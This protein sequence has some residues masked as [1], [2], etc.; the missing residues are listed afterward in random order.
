MQTKQLFAVTTSL[1]VLQCPHA[2]HPQQLLRLRWGRL[3]W[4]AMLVLLMVAI[5]AESNAAEFPGNPKTATT[6]ARKN[7]IVLLADDLGW[8][9]VGFHGG[10]ASTPNLDQLAKEGVELNRF[11][12]YPACSPARAAMLTGRFPHRFGITGPT[13]PRDEGLPVSEKMLPAVFQSAGYQ[14]SLIGK[15]HLGHAQGDAA[16]PSNRGF[17]SF[18][19]FMGASVDYFE[20]TSRSRLDWQRDGKAIKEEGYSTDL[21]TDEAIRQIENRDTSKPFCIVLSFNAPHTPLQAPKELIAKYANL[22]GRTGTYAAMIESMDIGIG[23]ILKSIDDQKLSDETIVV[24]A[25]DNGAPRVGV[26]APFR[27]QKRQVYEGGIHVPCI[28]RSPG[29]LKAGTKSNQLAKIDD[30]FPTLADATGV[31]LNSV[32]KPLDGKSLWEHLVNGTTSPRSIVI[33]ETDHALIQD[34]WKIVESANGVELFNL[35]TDAAEAKNLAALKPDILAQL[36]AELGEFKRRVASDQPVS[37]GKVA[38]SSQTTSKTNNDGE[39]AALSSATLV[40]DAVYG[41]LG[42]VRVESNGRGVRLMSAIDP[43]ADNQIAGAVSITTNKVSANNR[44]YRFYISAFAQDNFAVDRDDLYLKV[45]FLKD[46]GSESLDMIKERIYPEVERVRKDFKDEGTNKNLGSGT[47]QNYAMDFRTPFAEIDSLKLSV[48]FAGGKGKGTQTEFWVRS[49]SL[50]PIDA[51]ENYKPRINGAPNLP[52]PKADSLVHL[53]GRWYFDPQGGDKSLPAQFDHTNSQ[54]LIYKSG[55]FER[56]FAGNMT[57]WLRAGYKDLN[58]DVVEKD[59]YR[60]DNL[61]IT[62]TKEHIVMASK[63][64]PNHPTATFPDRWRMLDGNPAYIQEQAAK[65][66][67]AINPNVNLDHVAM[68]KQ[69]ENQALPMGPIGVATNGVIFF[70]PF[71]HIFE[72]DA[73]WRLDRCC[74][75]PSPRS[76]YHYHKYPVCVKTPWSD[77]GSDHSPV[78][79]FA[80]DG[81]PVYGPYESKGLLARDDKQNPL[82]DFN[83]HEDELRGPHYHVTPGKFPHIIGGYWGELDQ[84]NRRRR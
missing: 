59:Q 67:I 27:G 4:A 42:D 16:H 50:E 45:E 60:P 47:W 83:L 1:E 13:R 23:R 48:G 70:N 24:F 53:G 71:D 49:M 77:E 28:I 5:A 44:W 33:A 61:V 75:H 52:Q 63:N 26:N 43:N 56:P 46:N 38:D 15:W 72:A 20:H 11:Y 17:D 9:D 30:L 58:G 57:S 19:G 3:S 35:K 21:L 82:N 74:G 32:S 78:I 25:S 22:N 29:D 34:D 41:V 69:N 80:F 81:F 36:T 2:K 31:D 40:G 39:G 84:A 68:N 54:Q 62:V 79:G 6:K 66:S 64:L 65:W 18:Y 55:K 12:A 8:G 37:F 10:N 76:Q 14:T 73:T 7:V 51:P